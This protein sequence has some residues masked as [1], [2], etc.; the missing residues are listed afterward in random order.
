MPNDTRRMLLGLVALAALSPLSACKSDT[1]KAATIAPVDI[2]RNTACEL[3]GMLLMDF[4]GPKGQIHYAGLPQPAFY[5]DTMEVINA[6]LVPEQ[7]RKVNAVYV[8]DMGQTDWDNPQGAWIDANTAIY[9]LG[10]RRKGSMG[11]TL[12]SFSKTEDAQAFAKEYGGQVVK[13]A[14][15][16]PEMVDLRG[17]AHLDHSM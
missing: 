10:S 12:A 9:V 5:C 7:V 17:G 6:L 14:D 2:T 11:P 13:M 1:E 15:I 16:K 8:Q 4:P 3:D